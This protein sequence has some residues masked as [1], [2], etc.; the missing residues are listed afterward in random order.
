MNYQLN[1]AKMFADVT[2]GIAI[3]INSMTGVYYGMNGLGTGMFDNFL[4]GAS[5]DDVL[6][7]FQSLP[8]APSDCDARLQA[9]I[10]RLKSFEIIV[11]AMEESS[12]PVTLSAKDAQFD[13]FTPTC[14]EYN[15]VQ[16]L[17]FADPIHEVKEDEGWK[18]EK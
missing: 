12:I 15:D 2:D 6:A 5:V 17:L 16:E 4:K 9:F 1:E 7:A 3:I 8:G 10:D 13:E 11:P 18:P 14:N